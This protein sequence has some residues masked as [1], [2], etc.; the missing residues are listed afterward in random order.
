MS[1]MVSRGNDLIPL[2]RNGNA[3]ASGIKTIQIVGYHEN[4]QPQSTLQG[5]GPVSSKSPAPI[6]SSPEVGSS[7]KTSSGSSASATRQARHGLIM[8]PDQLW[9]GNRSATSG[10]SPTMPSLATMISS[11]QALR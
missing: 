5:C 8:P 10:R 4:R 6:G 1:A 2:P 9:T 11:R 7:R 3:V